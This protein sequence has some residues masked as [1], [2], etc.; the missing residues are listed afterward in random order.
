MLLNE[1]VSWG[2]RGEI[3]GDVGVKLWFEVRRWEKETFH[4][5]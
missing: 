1:G 3:G 5:C 2:S 4:L